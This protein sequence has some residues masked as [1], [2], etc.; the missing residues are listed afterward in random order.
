M[1]F[2]FG[3]NLI[4]H[5]GAGAAHH[6]WLNHGAKYG[7]AEGPSGNAYAIPTKD[8]R[9]RHTLPL[10]TIRG[11][12]ET[13]KIYARMSPEL[14]FQV[15]RIGCGLAGLRDEDIAPMFKDAPDNCQ[16]DYSWIGI[17]GDERTYWGSFP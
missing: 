15:T 16:F 10:E 17:L 7:Q 8:R 6:A 3:S 14:T 11:Y 9:I 2:V 12:V 4:G 13:F 1:I 5:H